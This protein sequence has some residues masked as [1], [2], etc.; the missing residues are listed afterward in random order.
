MRTMRWG[1]RLSVLVIAGGLIAVL[2]AC[3]S[4]SSTTPGSGPTPAPTTPPTIT[5]TIIQPVTGSVLI[6]PNVTVVVQVSGFNL[7]DKNGQANAAGEGHINYFM[8]VDAP[9]TQGR[10]AITAIGTYVASS[11]TSYQWSDVPDGVH[12]FSVELV[13][14]DNT[15]LDP[16]VVAKVTVTV[17]TG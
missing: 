12:T 6:D 7:V 14:N 15:P 4:P 8:G 2:S 17:F 10:P 9:T 13:N 11:S 3:T 1:L 16:P 5:I